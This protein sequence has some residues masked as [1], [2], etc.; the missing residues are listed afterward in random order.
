[1][2]DSSSLIGFLVGIAALLVSQPVLGRLDRKRIRENVEQRGSKV[3]AMKRRF[4]WWRLGARYARTYD[5]TYL[6]PDSKSITATCL[7]SMTIGVS[8]MNDRPPQ[9]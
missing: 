1:M 2:S 7:T 5:V 4:V 6:T 8:W 9:N 3:I